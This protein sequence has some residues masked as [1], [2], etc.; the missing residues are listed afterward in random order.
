L[1]GHLQSHGEIRQCSP[2]RFENESSLTIGKGVF[3]L[4]QIV[5]QDS[6]FH[7]R[8][9]REFLEDK[10]GNDDGQKRTLRGF[11]AL[12]IRDD[13]RRFHPLA[14]H[15]CEGGNH[16]AQA[17]AHWST[18]DGVGAKVLIDN[19]GQHL[20]REFL[21]GEGFAAENSRTF[22]IGIGLHDD[23]DSL[24]VVWPSGV[25]QRIS[26][27]QAGMLY[28]VYE[29][30]QQSPTGEAFVPSPYERVRFKAVA[31]ADSGKHSETVLDFVGETGHGARL[32]MYTLT[33]TTCSACKRALPRLAS[34]KAAFGD[35]LAM[36]GVPTQPERDSAE[37]WAH[38]VEKYHPGYEPLV[39]LSKEN[40]DKVAGEL[41]FLAGFG[42]GKRVCTCDPPCED[43]VPAP[44]TVVTDGEGHVITAM[45]GVPSV[46]TIRK[47]LHDMNHAR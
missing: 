2:G 19:H 46:S 32:R 25:E 27:A 38:Y 29:N 4:A 16:G 45:A 22:L 24:K 6:E 37:D 17:D 21:C 39:G 36:Y 47:I 20:L 26:G 41:V 11:A 23:V 42:C 3:G 1:F 28:T 10:A 8:P 35:E 31:A 15:C 40:V 43:G 9:S 33:Y 18:R 5:G 12:R 44:S 30:P 7:R 13:V 14:R 34:L